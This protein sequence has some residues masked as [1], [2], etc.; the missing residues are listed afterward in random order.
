[1]F[2]EIYFLV[3][4]KYYYMKIYHISHID[5]SKRI[6]HASGENSPPKNSK[7]IGHILKK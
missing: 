2:P 3:F 6:N 4:N 5:L 7:G 1:M